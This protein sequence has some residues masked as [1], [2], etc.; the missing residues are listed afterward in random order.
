MSARRSRPST[1][2]P[3]ISGLAWNGWHVTAVLLVLLRYLVPTEGAEQGQTLWIAAA[4]LGF[5]AVRLWWLSRHDGVYFPAFNAADFGVGLLVLGNAVSAGM[6][7][8]TQGD[9]RAALNGLWEWASI[10]CSWL[11]LRDLL[12][13]PEM[14]QLLARSLWILCIVLMV[15][16][17]W[18]HFYWYPQQAGD[19]KELLALQQKRETQQTLSAVEAQ[20][21]EKLNSALGQTLFSLDPAGQRTLL[22]RAAH[23]VEPIGRFALANSFAAVLI[24]GFFLSLQVAWNEFQHPTSRSSRWIAVIIVLLIVSCLLLTKSR[25]AIAAV[26]LVLILRGLQLGIRQAFWTPA[27]RRIAG[28]VVTALILIP[29][30]LTLSGGLDREVISEAPKSLQYRIEYWSGTLGLI[31]ESPLF[32]VG[33]GNFRQH[34][35]KHKLPGSSEEILDPH[36]YLLDAWAHGGLLALLGVL[37]LTYLAA[38]NLFRRS[39]PVS[40]VDNTRLPLLPV[41]LTGAGAALIVFAEQWLFEGFSD[42]AVLS[43]L[44]GFIVTAAVMFVWLPVSA[45]PRNTFA[46]ACGALLLHL[47]GAG[48]L[49]MPAILQ[50]VLLLFLLELIPA[51]GASSTSPRALGAGSLVFGLLTVGCLWT[52]L[53]PVLKVTSLLDQSRDIYFRQGNARAAEKLLKEAAVADPLSPE[54]HQQLGMLSYQQWTQR[55]T[56]TQL[57]DEAVQE[58][59]EAIR[60]DPAAGKRWLML[61]EWWNARAASDGHVESANH[62]VDAAR[63]GLERYPHYAPLWVQLALALEKAGESAAEA[64]SQAIRLDDLNH[65]NRHV[66]KYLPDATRKHLETLSMAAR[67]PRKSDADRAPRRSERMKSLRGLVGFTGQDAFPWSS[68]IVKSKACH[69]F[70]T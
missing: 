30:I 51:S 4:W 10:G 60:R 56:E 18:Q 67:L 16:G 32:G 26:T 62:A 9:Q 17:F 38:R 5:A 40:L 41:A 1:A 37:V 50:L 55:R 44:L 34:Y 11:I 47:L 25:T 28:G 12:R 65:K 2:S 57:F 29:M 64:A 61:A 31:S 48:G 49:S 46:A 63:Q 14:K 52:G 23:S 69:L 70:V 21:F 59:S 43:L 22:D 54:P 36:N 24:V 19:L 68:A 7:L 33:P 39:D 13:A 66:D 58:L 27:R 20:R 3:T 35:L 15:C 53:L 6:V 8:L 45:F 42:F